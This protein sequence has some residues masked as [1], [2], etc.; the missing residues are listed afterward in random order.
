MINLEFQNDTRVA[1]ACGEIFVDKGNGVKL[2]NPLVAAQNFE[3]KTS[4]FLDKPMESVFGFISVLPGAF[5]A[6]RYTA[7]QNG[8][9][10]KGPLETYFMGE[11]MQGGNNLIGS[12]MYLAEDR[13]L[14]F[15]LVC[16]RNEAWLLRYVQEARAATD[17]PDAIPEYLSQRRRWL[18]GSFF[19]GIHA[20]LH[21]YQIFSSSHSPIR[22]TIIVFQTLCILNFILDNVVVLAFN[23]F[24]LGS[25]Y[26]MLY[27]LTYRVNDDVFFGYGTVIALAFQQMYISTLILIFIAALANRPIA[28]RS[29]YVAAFV[30]FGLVM[31]MMMYLVNFKL[32]SRDTS[33]YYRLIMHSLVPLIL[34][35][36]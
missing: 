8:A 12:N 10:G 33:Y 36:P 4:N 16:K 13:I 24:S 2:L 15:E 29:L 30:L 20:I 5:S 3:Y 21:F 18:N 17:V 25:F 14:C 6:Y 1:G 23:W 19:A 28:S 22:K 26:L 35:M 34:C 32:T 7:L 27:F 31:L 9:D 11:T